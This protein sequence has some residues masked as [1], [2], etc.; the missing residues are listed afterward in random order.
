[1]KEV[2]VQR[3]G[4]NIFGE[5]QEDDYVCKVSGYYHTSTSFIQ[6]INS[7]AANLNKTYQD[8]MLFIV[9]D[10]VKKIKEHDYFTLNNIKYEIVD[11]GN[12]Q[13]IVYDT[14]LKKLN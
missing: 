12:I 2:T 9:N 13:D 4:E 3:Q 11:M 6:N 10:D 8:K 7:D 5:K 1:M 14:S